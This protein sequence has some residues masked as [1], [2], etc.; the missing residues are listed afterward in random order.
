M[1]NLMIGIRYRTKFSSRG[2]TF[3]LL[4]AFFRVA[5]VLCID[6]HQYYYVEDT[7]PQCGVVCGLSSAE[8]KNAPPPHNSVMYAP[9][10][11]ISLL[12]SSSRSAHFSTLA[13]L[14]TELIPVHLVYRYSCHFSLNPI[15]NGQMAISIAEQRK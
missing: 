12:T 11:R 5:C 7:G 1:F 13:H 6:A 4:G 2:K 8:P 15:P 14:R 9:P 3:L 10:L